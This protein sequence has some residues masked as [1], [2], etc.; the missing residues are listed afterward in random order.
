MARLYDWRSAMNATGLR[1][2]LAPPT[3]VGA[4]ADSARALLTA[5][6]VL[7]GML[8]AAEASYVRAADRGELP[9]FDRIEASAHEA[10]VAWQSELAAWA[11]ALRATHIVADRAARAAEQRQ[12]LEQSGR[13]ADPTAFSLD[14]VRFQLAFE[15]VC[16]VP[17]VIVGE[18]GGAIEAP[19]HEP[20]T[21]AAGRNALSS[22]SPCL[23]IG[24]RDPGAVG[25][26]VRVQITAGSRGLPARIVGTVAGFANLSGNNSLP[27]YVNTSQRVITFEEAHPEH[28]GTGNNAA[29]RINAEAGDVVRAYLDAQGRL[30]IETRALGASAYLHVDTG[31]SS[32]LLAELGLAVNQTGEGSTTYNLTAARGDTYGRTEVYRDIDWTADGYAARLEAIA[33]G[34]VLLGALVPIAATR[35]DNDVAAVPLTGG[36]GGCRAALAQRLSRAA[37]LPAVDL[38]TVE[39]I[40]E[41]AAQYAAQWDGAPG[42]AWSNP[43][44][45]TP[46]GT[47]GR[48]FALPR[49]AY[50]FGTAVSD[51]VAMVQRARA[52]AALRS[53][54]SIM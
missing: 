23:R 54:A 34:S 52:L 28:L 53:F 6:E 18:S 41:L 51:L 1:A 20:L 14:G 37:R 2:T 38:L 11:V 5:A 16:P 50:T 30:V 39:A 47:T 25:R 33:A 4:A 12:F 49:E 46:V 32:P 45:D 15:D 42:F 35:P 40:N 26:Q 7:G 17:L 31:G 36:A 8:D 22:L 48:A 21:T 10:F 44:A 3:H 13:V 24:A 43:L 29:A 19:P 27:L 9:S